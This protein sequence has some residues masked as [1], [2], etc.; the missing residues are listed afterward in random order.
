[1][2]DVVQQLVYRCDIEILFHGECGW[3]EPQSQAGSPGRFDPSD[4]RVS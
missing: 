3:H 4:G 1:V 2:M